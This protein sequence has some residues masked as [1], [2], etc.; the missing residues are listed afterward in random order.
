MLVPK[1]S[2]SRSI[3]EK[4]DGAIATVCGRVRR[5]TIVQPIASE[6]SEGVSEPVKSVLNSTRHAPVLKTIH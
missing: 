3:D 5:K 1:A 6:G 2:E 4:E